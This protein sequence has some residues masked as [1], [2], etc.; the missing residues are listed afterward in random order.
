MLPNNMDFPAS[1]PTDTNEI[2]R[3]VLSDDRSSIEV[4]DTELYI[5]TDTNTR[6][7]QG[8]FYPVYTDDTHRDRF[9]FVCGACRSTAVGMDPMGRL[10]CRDCENE[11][12][13]TRWDAA[14][15]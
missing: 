4:D 10:A 3:S 7:S 8:M 2:D 14:Y 1:R 9:G 6:G 5:D 15:L 12:K 11:R 13:P